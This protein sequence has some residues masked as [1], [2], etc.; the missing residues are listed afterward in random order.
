MA[1]LFTSG[2]EC[3]VGKFDIGCDPKYPPSIEVTFRSPSPS[4]SSI[5]SSFWRFVKFVSNSCFLS[6]QYLLNDGT[7]M[8][9]PEAKEASMYPG[10]G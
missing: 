2:R 3:K 9:H 1:L 6:A 10:P 8:K 7:I 4:S 5:S